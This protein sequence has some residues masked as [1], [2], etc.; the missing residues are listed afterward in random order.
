MLFQS[1]KQQNLSKITNI[2]DLDKSPKGSLDAPIVDLIHEINQ[3]PDYVT[4]SSC[5]GRIAIFAEVPDLITVDERNVSTTSKGSG[6]WLLSSHS[7][8]LV[9]ETREFDLVLKAEPFIMHVLCRDF[10]SAEALLKV[11]LGCGFRESGIVVGKKL[12]KSKSRKTMCHLRT[13]ASGLEVPV[14]HGNWRMGHEAFKVMIDRANT[15]FEENIKKTNYLKEQVIKMLRAT[16]QSINPREIQR[17]RLKTTREQKHQVKQGRISSESFSSPTLG[18]WGHCVVQDQSKVLV[19]G[20]YGQNIADAS[21]NKMQRYSDVLMLEPTL[22]SNIVS[23]GASSQWRTVKPSCKDPAAGPR[24]AEH[25]AAFLWQGFLLVHGGRGNP[26]QPFD[27]LWCLDT[28]RSDARWCEVQAVGLCPPGRWGHTLTILGREE[29]GKDGNGGKILKTLRVLLYGGRGAQTVFKD[30]WI[31]TLTTVQDR[32]AEGQ[33]CP[34]AVFFHSCIWVQ[35]EKGGTGCALLIGGLTDPEGLLASQEVWVYQDTEEEERWCPVKQNGC[36]RGGIFGH[37]CVVLNSDTDLEVLVCGGLFESAEQGGIWL[38][39]ICDSFDTIVWTK[40]TGLEYGTEVLVHHGVM[41][42]S[43]GSAVTVGGGVYCSAFGPMFSPGFRY[44][45]LQSP[46]TKEHKKSDE[47]QMEE[48]PSFNCILVPPQQTKAVKNALEARKWMDKKKQIQKIDDRMGVP[49]TD[50]GIAAITVAGRPCLA[51]PEVDSSFQL[52]LGMLEF[53][54]SK[55][56]KADRLAQVRAMLETVV[57]QHG[58]PQEAWAAVPQKFELVGDAVMLSLEGAG[59]A[60]GGAG[61][62]KGSGRPFE[63]WPPSALEGSIYPGLLQTFGAR[64]VALKSIVDTGP[65][66]ESQAKLVWPVL[67]EEERARRGPQASPTWVTVRENGIDYGFDL[68][69]VMFCSGNNTER[70]RYAS[71]AHPWEVCA[72]LY[73]GIGYYTLPWL[74]HSK[75]RFLHAFEWNP[76]SVEALRDNL[77]RNGVAGRCRVHPGDN[78][79]TA[80]AQE[81]EGVADRVSLGLLPSSEEGW[82][83]AA[84]LLR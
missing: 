78:R 84:R 31:L 28:R 60:A 68:A 7:E 71:L 43:Q 36:I 21:N 44:R 13:S 61:G 65:R 49:L 70:I 38:G 11:G 29:T 50:Q 3:H 16:E 33:A 42:D 46:T 56:A 24:P 35:E 45:T 5:S 26:L 20:G 32:E 6:R 81:L 19:F 18:R 64:L 30:A 83:L 53:G 76:N 37:R 34:P 27:Q 77:S 74:V 75:V 63:G 59:G 79:E 8:E 62:L 14:A 47:G 23:L 73:S 40:K 17:P 15:R 10:D 54:Q 39:K 82:P 58:L 67:T 2:C 80:L 22:E 9:Q 69:R 66:R 72:D 51:L 12:K 52:D 41:I 25:A 4:T 57:A 48:I 1:I 55:T